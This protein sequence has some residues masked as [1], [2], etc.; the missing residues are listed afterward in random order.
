[1]QQQYLNSSPIFLYS[2]KTSISTSAVVEWSFDVS[3]ERLNGIFAP[4]EA[5]ILAISSSSVDTMISSKQLEF[6]AASIEYWII[7][8]PKKYFIFFLG[9][10]LLPPLAVIIAIFFSIKLFIS[11]SN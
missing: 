5:A 7:G 2:F 10:L 8:L 11:F 6:I 3:T 4:N 9:I 1:M